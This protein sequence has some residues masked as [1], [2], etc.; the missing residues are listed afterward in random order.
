MVRATSTPGPWRATHGGIVETVPAP[1]ENARL[2]ADVY[3]L[4]MADDELEEMRENACLLAAAP[5]LLL[6][7]IRCV[8]LLDEVMGITAEKIEQMG[9]D[10]ARW[11]AMKAIEKALE[12]DIR[13]E[14]QRK[15]QK[16]RG[17]VFS[18][19]R[20]VENGEG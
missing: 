4:G 17:A 11:E 2:I 5:D 7:L 14:E 16:P 19:P 15:N 9:Q 18:R 6:A 13:A 1:G 3:A 10:G 20:A 12:F 8:D